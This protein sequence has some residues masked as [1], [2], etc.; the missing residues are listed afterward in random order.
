MK[1]LSSNEW[2]KE[3]ERITMVDWLRIDPKQVEWIVAH[4]YTSLGFRSVVTSVTRDGGIDVFSER[5]D[6]MSD[7]YLK[8][9]IQVKRWKK[10]VSVQPVRELL[11]VKNDQKADRATMISISDY[12]KPA[13][14]FANRQNIELVNKEKFEDLLQ[15]AKLL[16]TDGSLTSISDPNL[17]QNRRKF[18][19]QI[20]SEARPMGLTPEQIINQVCTPRFKV[21]VKAVLLEQDIDELSSMGEIIEQD[22]KCFSRIPDEEVV[23]VTRSLLS[24]IQGFAGV[25]TEQDITEAL[26]NRYRIP[27]PTARRLV[28][29]RE[30]IDQLVSQGKISKITSGV[31]MLPRGFAELGRF[32]WTRDSIRGSILRLFN[33]S[34]KTLESNME[35]LR[36]KIGSPEG[37]SLQFYHKKPLSEIP[38]IVVLLHFCRDRYRGMIGGMLTLP[39]FVNP[40][41][42][43]TPKEMESIKARIMKR[44][45]EHETIVAHIGAEPKDL[46]LLKQRASELQRYGSKLVDLIKSSALDKKLEI[47]TDGETVA[48]AAT[49]SFD[50]KANFGDVMDRF[51]DKAELVNRFLIKVYDTCPPPLVPRTQSRSTRTLVPGS[52]IE[53][54]PARKPESRRPKRL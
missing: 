38:F 30:I 41:K 6:N 17:P 11:G 46:E 49:E 50:R 48:I 13:K 1:D 51:L 36:V 32:H 10:P 4:L 31:Y 19:H 8:H 16:K 9:V 18:I 3:S 54:K 5:F 37:G 24:D 53:K 27:V 29:V 21:T 15:K 20:L 47:G 25:F 42:A 39:L 43:M 35:D 26:Q 44:K 22:G 33:V 14:E 34:K 45:E 7:S 52:S 23:E 12:T 40:I 28:P 2:Q